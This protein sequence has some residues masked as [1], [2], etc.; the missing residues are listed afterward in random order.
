MPIA[1]PLAQGTI[2]HMAPEVLLKGQISKAS[3]VSD[4]RRHG[5]WVNACGGMARGLQCYAVA[6]VLAE[7]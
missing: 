5:P 2:T 1:L 3:D 7:S 4:M 6:L